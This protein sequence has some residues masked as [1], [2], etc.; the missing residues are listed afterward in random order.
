MARTEA[1]EVCPWCGGENVF[2]DYDVS[3]SGYIVKCRHCNEE[4]ML[5]DECLHCDDNPHGECDWHE[6]CHLPK[7]ERHFGYCF[8]G[9]TKHGLG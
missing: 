4:I 7:G 5:C 2:E 3:K 9:T 8:R 1:V 6:D